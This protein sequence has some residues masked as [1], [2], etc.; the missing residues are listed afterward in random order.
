MNFSTY[1][2]R[3]LGHYLYYS[4][5]CLFLILLGISGC[6]GDNEET[7]D[8]QDPSKNLVGTWELIT[9]N[10]KTQKAHFQQDTGDEEIELLDFA[11]K[12]VFASDGSLFQEMLFTVRILIESSPDLIYL[13][14]R[15]G[16][17]IKGSYVV[18]GST[19]EFIQSGD[20]INVEAHFSWE[21]PGNPELTQQLEQ[22]L[23]LEQESQ[24]AAAE[25]EQEFARDFG[26]ELDTHTFDLEGNIFTLMNGSVRVYRKR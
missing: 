10:G 20:A 3:I 17:T 26:L 2:R 23:D 12:V 16:F 9:V 18:S 4:A 7:S 21:T 11:E 14:V 24:E 8:D 6:G 19:V 15:M 13:R 25:A 1:T 5:L 22:L